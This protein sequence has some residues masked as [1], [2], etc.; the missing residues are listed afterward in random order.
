MADEPRE[1][2]SIAGYR[3][4]LKMQW[5]ALLVIV[6]I[7]GALAGGESFGDTVGKGCGC[8]VMI[9]IALLLLVVS[10]LQNL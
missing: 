2:V 5:L 3:E 4:E 6:I 9:G 8:L 7:L 1:Q 10:M